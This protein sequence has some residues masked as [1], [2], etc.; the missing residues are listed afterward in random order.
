MT[1][2]NVPAPTFGS[3]GFIPSSQ[4]AI[5]AGVQADQNAAFGGNLNPALT[6]PQGQLA[7]SLAAIIGATQSQFA[8]LANGVDPAFASGRMQDAVG[9]IYFLSRNP[10]Q[11]TIVQCTCVGAVGTVIPAATATASDTSGN[12]YACTQTGT[13]PV[14]GSIVLS[15]AA[16]VNGPTACPTG[17]L[18]SIQQGVPGWNS[19]TNLAPGVAGNYAET[20]QAFSLRMSQS[21]AGNSQN[22]VQ[23]IQAAVYNVP[24]VISAFTTDNVNTYPVAVGATASMTGYITAGVLTVTVV[25]SGT[26]VQGQSVSGVGVTFGTVIS[27][28]GSGTGGLGTYNLSVV[29][30]VTATTFQIGGFQLAPNSVYCCVAGGASSAIAAAIFSKKQPG[31]GLQGNT[32]IVVYDTSAPYLPPG[33]PYTITYNTPTNV[34]IYFAISIANSAVVPANALTQIQTAILSTFNGT[35]NYTRVGIGAR[36][37]ASYFTPAIAALGSWAQVVSLTIGSSINAYAATFTGVIAT[38]SNV[39]TASAVTGTISAGQVLSG[40]NIL[41]G[42]TVVAFLSGVNGGAGTYQI[43]VAQT[44]ASATVNCISVTYAS[45]QTLV[46][47]MPVASAAGITLSL[48]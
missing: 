27:T 17:A 44:A 21:V 22:G 42:T 43:S 1:T 24:N 25:N 9:R 34:E 13:I 30:N 40:V 6:T 26:I 3:T 18:N 12:I 32:P 7:Q 39:I 35:G 20:Q 11:P 14:G 33:I 31:C 38:G 10:A 29:Q 16:V 5:L 23:A 28:F 36:V 8:A 46:N 45:I 41:D 4:S 15:F 37:L 48:V 47:Q 19:I 2:T